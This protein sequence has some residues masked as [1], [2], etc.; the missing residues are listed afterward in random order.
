MITAVTP[1]LL[2]RGF[3]IRREH[4]GVKIFI[5]I[6]YFNFIAA[7]DTGVLMPG[8]DEMKN[9]KIFLFILSLSVILSFAP[10][11][12][13]IYA[14]DGEASA[15]PEL[16]FCFYT[17]DG[18]ETD[19]NSLSPGDY[20]ADLVLTGISSAAVIQAE[21]NLKNDNI[22]SKV[23]IDSTL[24]DRDA[25][26][27]L[28]FSGYAAD[29]RLAVI[30]ASKETEYS[31]LDSTGTVIA[32]L[33]FSVAGDSAVDFA[34]CFVFETDSDLTFV[35]VTYSKSS[36]FALSQTSS[37][38]SATL[39]KADVTPEFISDIIIKGTVYI[40]QD[41]NGTIGA[42]GAR[43]VKFI[44]N[45]EYLRD[46]SGNIITS[47]SEPGHYGEFT[48]TVPRGTTAVTLTT[49]SSVDRTVYLSGKRNVDGVSFCLVTVDYNKDSR[50]N[51]ADFAS[52]V[53]SSDGISSMSYDL[54]DD[55]K[56][57]AADFAVF[58]YLLNKDIVYGELSIDNY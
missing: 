21:A 15:A 53:I 43:G 4:V 44:V 20:T 17:S 38:Y 37:A 39:M 40:S 14:S 48:L 5:Y 50:V 8:E 33:S 49:D 55:N 24:A 46:S 32:T 7:A 23:N 18:T 52:F 34:D 3:V 58:K 26:F 25:N 54:T 42:F 16:S 13:V 29:G 9:L 10:T 12:S 2:T 22:V 27:E 51:A 19:G 11:E 6:L 47:S 57:N 30:L 41:E 1:G 36:V 35:Q 31:S 56:I 28:A 45:G